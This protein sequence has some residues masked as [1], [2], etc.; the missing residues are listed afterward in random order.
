MNSWAPNQLYGVSD[1][2]ATHQINANYLWE[3]PFGR[4]KHFLSS[5]SRLAD[6]LV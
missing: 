1:F 4:G 6:E 2:D 5:T 3:L